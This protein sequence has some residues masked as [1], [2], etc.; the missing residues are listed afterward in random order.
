MEKIEIGT[1]IKLGN[2]FLIR[3]DSRDPEIIKKLVGKNKINLVLCDPPY[4]VALVESKTGF[5]GNKNNFKPIEND[6][7]QSDEEYRRFT[8]DW[9]SAVKPYLE[10]KNSLYIFNSDKKIFALRDGMIESGCRF[11]QLLIW[12]KTNAVIG[13]LDYLPQHELIAYGWIGTHRFMRSKDKSILVYPKP[14]KSPYHPSTKPVGLLRR[15]ILNSTK[16]N[17]FV[18]DNFG[19]SGSTLMAAEQTNRRCLMVEMDE[20]Y[21]KTIASRFEKLTGIEAEEVMQ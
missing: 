17:D 19:G 5:S 2:H 9:I 15:L 1:V 7:E 4:G 12:A 21:C 18:Y 11:S 16:I 3:G 14:Q 10:K 20:E 8:S 6:H 13:R